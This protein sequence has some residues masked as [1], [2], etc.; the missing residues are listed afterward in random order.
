M[1]SFESMQAGYAAMWNTMEVTRKEQ[2]LAAARRIIAMRPIYEEAEQKTGAPWWFI[3]ALHM[4]ESNNNMRGCLTNGEMIIGTNKKT[5]LETKGR[6]P[7]PTWVDSAIDCA[8]LQGWDKV[9]DWSI[10]RCLYEGEAFNGWG[11]LKRGN[12]PY[13]WAGTN[14]YVKGKYVSDGRYSASH[15]DTQLGIACVMKA[16][17]EITGAKSIPGSRTNTAAGFGKW[18]GIGGGGAV[19]IAQQFM[20]FA[21]D[22]RTIAVIMAVMVG[23]GA[24]FWYNQ[25]QKLREYREGRYIP[26]KQGSG[27][28]DIP[29]QE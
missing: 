8:I 13:V 2:A 26:S 20:G 17:L 19:G 6:G 29:E 1:P 10:E 12:S 9:S 18:V 21:T 5:R 24:L 15:V 28:F 23:A 3:G 14:H 25:R 7:F 11:Y 27:F 22:W 16:I 4:R